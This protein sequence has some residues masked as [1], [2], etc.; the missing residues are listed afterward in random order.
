V[1][2]Y[3]AIKPT[4]ENDIYILH[5]AT[6]SPFVRKTWIFLKEKGLEFE[7]RQ[8]DPLDKSPRFLAMN[9]AGRIP[10]LEEADGHFIADSSVICDYLER[11]HP[12]PAMFP[13]DHRQ[14]ARAL[15]LEE[16]AD[17]TLN[18]LCARIFWMHIIIPVRTG[19]PANPAEIE[20]FKASEY[21]AIF[22]YLESVAPDGE[23]IVG[24]QFGIADIALAAPVRLLDLAGDPLD[25]A[26][27]PRFGR[28][29]DRTI[30]RESAL[31]IVQHD[32]AATEAWRTTGQAPT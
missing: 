20:A 32:L 25:H 10:V 11:V 17:T 29:Y 16:Y 5:G 6:S 3:S 24:G 12:I 30:G 21:P 26:R 2:R 9:P 4:L 22:D 7:H 23:G 13:S 14:R 1:L 18:S 27:W 8:L 19:E 31:S 15:W 28:Y